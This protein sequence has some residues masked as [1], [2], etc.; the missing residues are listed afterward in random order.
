MI[1]KANAPWKAGIRGTVEGDPKARAIEFSPQPS[2]GERAGFG[3]RSTSCWLRL[4]RALSPRSK[5]SRSFRSSS[6]CR[7]GLL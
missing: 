1:F 6:P 2:F 5:P 3:A 4:L 7:F